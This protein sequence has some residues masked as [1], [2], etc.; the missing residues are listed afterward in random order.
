MWSKKSTSSR[1]HSKSEIKERLSKAGQAFAL[2]KNIWKSKNISL[3]TKLRFF[4]SNVLTTLLYGYESWK[5]T[6]AIG[7][8]LDT[9]QK[10][11]AYPES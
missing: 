6:K 1:T 9:F 4:K 11:A 10:I 7:H 3:K 8:R 5:L 2:L